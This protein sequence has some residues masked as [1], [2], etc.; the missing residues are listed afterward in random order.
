MKFLFVAR[1]PSLF[2]QYEKVIRNL[3][4]RGH[5][6]EFLLNSMTWRNAV[7]D[8]NALSGFVEESAG[9]FT[10]A[11]APKPSG[12]GNYLLR[13]KRELMNYAAYLRPDNPISTSPYMVERAARAM[14]P[15]MHILGR[16]RLLRRWLVSAMGQAVMRRMEE[17]IRPHSAI[18]R[19]IAERKPDLVLASPFLFSRSDEI[20]FIKA[21]KILGI[22]A[23]VAI[24]SWDNLT[25]K[26]VFQVEPDGV[27]VWNKA[28]VHELEAIHKIPQS[29][30][31][32]TGAPSLDF[33]FD[34]NPR[35]SREEF[36]RTHGLDPAR[37]YVVYLC[38]SQTIAP[39]EN[40]FVAELI[41]V[42]QARLGASCPSILIR[43]HPLNLAIWEGFD[44]PGAVVVP[45]SNRDIFY[46]MEARHLFFDT[47]HHSSCVMGLNTTAMVESAIVGKPC[48]TI[49]AAHY[50]ATQEQSGHF[51]HL[52][53]ANLLY[54]A[55][56]LPEVAD[57]VHDLTER[58]DE[59]AAARAAFVQSFVR[60]WG[61][62][63]PSHGIM[64]HALE[65]LAQR[66][67]PVDIVRDIER[68]SPHL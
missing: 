49:P 35:Q 6:I 50:A 41:H 62:K 25:S 44:E 45:R 55:R 32:W 22:P 23:A 51:H 68:G 13:H 52:T 28:Q 46:S 8:E 56:T 64:T 10:F 59:K 67:A 21:A 17:A 53:D 42:L 14:Y 9:A 60:P 11:P 30:A 5:R 4:G 40:I 31:I 65:S 34:V 54:V 47:F 2:F 12:L 19:A 7:M 66:K 39:D 26:G 37:P 48:L 43:P 33:W 38:S 15:P 36:C 63:R 1:N 18:I 61:L 27:L 58:R 3:C 20:D 24:F 16:N 29:K 57:M